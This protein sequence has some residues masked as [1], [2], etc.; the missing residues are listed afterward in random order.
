MNIYIYAHIYIYISNLKFANSFFKLK[1]K[2]KKNQK[3]YPTKKPQKFQD[4][5][6]FA[7]CRTGE[8]EKQNSA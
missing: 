2:A 3:K 5:K 1:K 8:Q 4:G 6:G 7:E